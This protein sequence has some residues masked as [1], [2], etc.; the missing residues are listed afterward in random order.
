M[1]PLLSELFLLEIEPLKMVIDAPRPVQD[2]YL[3]TLATVEDKVGFVAA[4]RLKNTFPAD[5]DG[6]N[7]NANNDGDQHGGC[8]YGIAFGA[9]S[10][11]FLMTVLLASIMSQATS[12]GTAIYIGIICF[13]ITIGIVPLVLAYI[14]YRRKSSQ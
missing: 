12:V 3:E 10:I 13:I 6:P 1:T 4:L 5:D 11:G 8:S 2:K 9:L 7:D 14:D